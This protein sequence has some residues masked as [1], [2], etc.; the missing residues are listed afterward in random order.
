ML[1]E[2][3]DSARLAQ[4]LADESRDDEKQRQP[5]GVQPPEE[6][7]TDGRRLGVVNRP[8][9]AV[10][11][12]GHVRDRRMQHDPGDDRQTTDGIQSSEA[13]GTARAPHRKR[14]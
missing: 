3:L 2:S 4:H 10:H 6:V 12:T 11:A 9:Q 14:D 1:Q 5:K 7:M 13:R 8:K